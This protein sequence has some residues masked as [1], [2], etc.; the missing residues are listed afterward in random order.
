MEITEAYKLMDEQS[1]KRLDALNNH[2]VKEIV[3]HY[4]ALCRPAKITVLDD[5]KDS[6]DYARKLSLKNG[7][8]K[9][10]KMSGHTIHFD[11]IKD[12][13]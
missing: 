13:G 5:S 7:E 3:D 2:H 12:Q 4:A 9:P 10:L 11:S 6:I 8:E 1:R